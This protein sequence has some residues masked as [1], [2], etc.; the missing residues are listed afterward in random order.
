MTG[1]SKNPHGVSQGFLMDL[2]TEHRGFFIC[3]FLLPISVALNVIAWV[4][5]HL[6]T[7]RSNAKGHTKRVSEI[8]SAV[9]AASKTGQK[10][11]TDR[12][13]YATMSL[14]GEAHKKNHIKIP[15][16]NSLVDIID[17]NTSQLTVRVEP[18]VNMGQLSRYLIPRGFTLEVL[19]ELDELTVGGLLMGFGI[20]SSS[21]I[22]GLFQEICVEYEVVLG[23]GRVV[24][25]RADNEYSD[26]FYA[27]PWSYG[28]L[29]L[30]VGA[31]LKIMRCEPFVRV[32]YKKYSTLESLTAAF[33]EA[34]CKK[35]PARFVESLAYGLNSAVVM[36]ADFCA[37]KVES[38]ASFNDIGL[39]F[40]KW[41]YVHVQEVVATARDGEAVVEI[42]PLRSYYHRH[43]KGIF[44]EMQHI[45]PFADQAWFR[46]L[47]GWAV[48]P[49]LPLMK[50]TQTAAMKKMWREQFVVQDMLVPITDLKELMIFLDK[51]MRI[52][53]MWLCPHLVKRHAMGG[54]LRPSRKCKSSENQEMFVDIGIYGVPQVQPYHHHN[55]M[56]M[57]E[58]KVRDVDGYQGLYAVCYMDKEEFRTM[59]HHELYDTC[60]VKY[61]GINAFPDVFDKAGGTGLRAL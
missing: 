14:K 56:R 20:E 22:A 52:Y 10:L 42:M 5:L 38:G 55:D 53:P 26:L 54:M 25:A 2:V 48:P 12:P 16:K 59:F 37:S 9:L 57:L 43:T 31:T 21:H 1:D 8:S 44:W 19:P 18:L 40:K 60:R 17:I 34:S 39:W 61:G 15:M 47:L 51:K 46:Y 58:K 49:N 7:L 29:G 36:E 30:V 24:F 32:T 50:S 28:T 23:D 35:N 45:I 11:C 33:Q 4:R 27:L 6:S 13:G 3:V 41:F